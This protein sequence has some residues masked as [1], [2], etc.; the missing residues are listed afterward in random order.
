MLQLGAAAQALMAAKVPIMSREGP[1]HWLC[2]T[3]VSPPAAWGARDHAPACGLEAALR[4][5]GSQTKHARALSHSS[6]HL[7]CACRALHK[8]LHASWPRQVM[9]CGGGDRGCTAGL[10]VW[11]SRQPGGL[12][13]PASARWGCC[14]RMSLLLA[15]LLMARP[16]AGLPPDQS[17]RAVHVLSL[18]ALSPLKSDD[19]EWQ[20]TAYR[21]ASLVIDEVWG[22]G[23][24][25]A[26]GLQL[27]RNSLVPVLP[28]AEEQTAQQQAAF[29]AQLSPAAAALQ[30]ALQ[31]MQAAS[32]T[33]AEQP[34]TEPA[35]P[36][37][38]PPAEPAE[39]A[40]QRPDEPAEPAEQPPAE[41][42]APPVSLEELHQWALTLRLFVGV[43]IQ[44][45][46]STAEVAA[47]LTDC[48]LLLSQAAVVGGGL[49]AAE[50]AAALLIGWVSKCNRRPQV[51]AQTLVR[52]GRLLAQAAER[53]EAD[54]CECE[55]A[56]IQCGL[57]QPAWSGAERQLGLLL[58]P[59]P[60]HGRNPM[61]SPSHLHV[62]LPL[63]V[64]SLVHSRAPD[65]PPCRSAGGPAGR[66]HTQP[67]AAPAGGG[68]QLACCRGGAAGAAA[69][70]AGPQLCRPPQALAAGRLHALACDGVGVYGGSAAPC[71]GVGLH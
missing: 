46:L 2:N 64:H 42:P 67:A 54:Q 33:A 11:W 43:Q 6:V 30:A 66:V 58:F 28:A 37:E 16:D 69:A 59:A 35:E 15:V 7:C 55:V 24:W 63:I 53:A 32:G 10:M 8:A 19:T 50:R 60:C 36:A 49:M 45:H 31:Q 40:E 22:D 56:C 5:S 48:Q 38:Q 9:C 70:G 71:G 52:L 62:F 13:L 14:F 27:A 44:E 17:L 47:L 3:T 20:L 68:P 12:V 39:P 1:F 21:C 34:P 18:L 61:D 23:D 4:P 51:Q 65:H 41:P 26:A 25:Q 29:A 57:V